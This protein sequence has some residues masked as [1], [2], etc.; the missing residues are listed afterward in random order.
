MEPR[1][2]SIQGLQKNVVLVGDHWCCQGHGGC[3]GCI[4][5]V[6]GVLNGRF[7]EDVI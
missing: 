2:Y 4:L 3:V 5:N 7:L 6:V 1:G